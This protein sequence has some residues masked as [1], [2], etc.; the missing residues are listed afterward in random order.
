MNVSMKYIKDENG[1]VF[2]PIV[3]IGSIYDDNG[4]SLLDIFYPVGSY[5]ET[6]DWTFNP[7]SSWGGVW[8]EELD[9]TV[10]VSWGQR[11]SST[12]AY[13]YGDTFG[14]RY[15]TLT[16]SNMPSHTHSF[17]ATTGST[18]LTGSVTIGAANSSA[19]TGLLNTISGIFSRSTNTHYYDNTDRVSM[20]G[21]YNTLNIDATHTHS[22]SGTT[23]STGSGSSFDIAQPSKVV[24]RWHRT[25]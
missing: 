10:L 15:V 18:S 4:N 16:S 11:D 1:N 14:T 22:V 23:G 6:S 21:M 9:G 3:N 2:S 12:A 17:S 5:Y 24:V 19:G 20:S 13:D 7:N 25:A 8:E